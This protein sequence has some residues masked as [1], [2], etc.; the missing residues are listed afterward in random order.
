MKKAVTAIL[1]LGT[2]TGCF[3]LYLN[4]QNRLAAL[5]LQLPAKQAELRLLN[6]RN[7]YLY[8]ALEAWESPAHLLQLLKESPYSSL[9][10]PLAGEVLEVEQCVVCQTAGVISEPT[11]ERHPLLVLGA[12]AP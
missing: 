2:L 10:H 11:E 1:F 9:K 12:S 5:Q 4:I 3:F 8:F 6:E 7:T